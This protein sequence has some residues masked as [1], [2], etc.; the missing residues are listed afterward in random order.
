MLEYTEGEKLRRPWSSS[1]GGGGG[2]TSLS[3][4]SANAA[5]RFRFGTRLLREKGEPS[6]GRDSGIPK[7]HEVLEDDST[8]V[9]VDI[10]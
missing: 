1:L 9:M 7:S 8:V 2:G 6:A 10:W 5:L 3:I 4:A